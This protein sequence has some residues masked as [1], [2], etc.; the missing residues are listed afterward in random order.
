MKDK[1]KRRHFLENVCP[2]V[3]LAMFGVTLV[4]ACS[5]GDDDSGTYSGTSDEITGY[6]VDGNSVSIDLDDASFSTLQSRGWMNFRQQNMLLL[7]LNATTYRAFTNSC[8][9]AGSRNA[10]SYNDTQERFVCSSHNN[11]YPSDCS[12]PGTTDD[13]LECYDTSL[14]GSTLTVTKS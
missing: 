1:Y 12:T 9:H 7:K 2:Q 3:A 10:W 4:E 5:K 8:P 6:T 14:M 13:V 11:S